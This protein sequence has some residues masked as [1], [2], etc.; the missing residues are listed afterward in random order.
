MLDVLARFAWQS[1]AV[2][3]LGAALFWWRSGA[4]PAPWPCSRGRGARV[5]LPAVDDGAGLV[6]G[7][8]VLDGHAER[9]LGHAAGHHWSSWQR[10]VLGMRLG[11]TGLGQKSMLLVAMAVLLLW[12]EPRRGALFV[13]GDCQHGF[14]P[15][16][17]C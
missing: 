14:F 3:A 17:R 10:L 1:A 15:G 7:V 2:L 11:Q 13:P 12:R 16:Q 4:I 6:A 8:L 5:A 9:I